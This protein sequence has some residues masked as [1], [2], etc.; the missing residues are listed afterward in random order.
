M[1]NASHASPDLEKR[2]GGKAGITTPETQ[3][4]LHY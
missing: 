4:V 1:G 3:T 2:S